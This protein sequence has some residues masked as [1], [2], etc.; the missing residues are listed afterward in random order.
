MLSTSS[1]PIPAT[2]IA[3]AS[4]TFP[5]QAVFDRMGNLWVSDF[6]AKAVYEFTPSQLASGGT[7]VAPN[8]T[9]TA[10]P[11]FAGPLGIAFDPRGDLFI[12]NNAGTTI[13]E[14]N[15]GSLPASGSVALAPNAVPSD[16]GAGSI[17]APWG[18]AFDMNGNLWSSNAN[19]P[20][21]IVEFAA[22]TTTATGKPTPAI[23][24][25]PTTGNGF[26][27]LAA[28]NGIAFDPAGDLA[29]I[30]SATPFGV[31]FY[32]KAQLGASGATIP[33]VFLVGAY[34]TLNAP[35]GDTFGPQY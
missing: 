35:A 28:P 4:F 5:Q 9:I 12:A 18:L 13:D 22:A 31:A 15:A 33:S 32:G 26:A 8:A 16:D 30:S 3:S 6:G 20:Q 10:N 7:N 17:Q 14:F 24:I 19:P 1:S 27:T 21:T 34:T 2:T 29:A 23:T 11:A 25:S